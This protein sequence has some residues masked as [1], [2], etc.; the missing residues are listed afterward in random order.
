M[1]QSGELADVAVGDLT[2]WKLWDHTKLILAQ[3][4]KPSH[5]A[6]IVRNALLRYALLCPQPE[7]KAFVDRLRQQEPKLVRE[8]EEDLAFEQ[9]K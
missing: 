8:L 7:A 5:S 6:P 4:G 9:G 2:R 1:I 3:Y